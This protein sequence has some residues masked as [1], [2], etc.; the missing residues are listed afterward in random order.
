MIRR[1]NHIGIAVKDIDSAAKVY[2]DAFGLKVQ[3]VEVMEAAGVKIALI[4][5]GE[6]KI[7][8][9]E[10]TDPEGKIARFIEEKGEGLNHLAFEVSDIEAVLDLLKAKGV[11]LVDE[12]PRS[13]AGGARIAY[14]QPAAAGG[15]SLE[16]VEPGC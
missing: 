14:L 5:V 11:P 8:L 1:V 9:V 2:A 12:K 7:E 10:P 15:V 3:D 13:G 4:P 16:L 6:S